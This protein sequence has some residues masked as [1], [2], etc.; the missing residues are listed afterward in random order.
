[1]TAELDLIAAEQRLE[2]QVKNAQEIELEELKLNNEIASLRLKLARL[3]DTKYKIKQETKRAQ[4]ERDSALRKYELEKETVS[5]QKR[6]EERLE[7]ARELLES[8]TWY[9][10]T[11][12]LENHA[13]KW[14]VDGALQLP[15]R[16]LL[17]D[18][19]GLGKTLSSLIWRRVHSIKK[20]LI[21]VRKEVAFDFLKE[22]SIREPNLFVYQ[23]LG[24]D[25]DSRNIAASLLNHQKEFVVITNIESWRKN[26]DKT[27]QDILKIKYDGMI[28]DEA[29]HIKNVTSATAQGFFRLS[30]EIPKVLELTGTPIKNSPL[31]MFSLLH[32]LYPDLFE[33]ESKFKVD[34]C[35]Q[36]D[37]NKWVFTESGLKSLVAK[38]SPFYLARSP[39]D[40]GRLV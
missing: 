37:Q 14:Q 20:L 5:I 40:V 30:K 7:S 34:Y 19:R 8:A 2:L 36:M 12:S 11:Y 18:K 39:E 32:A 17:G 21:C 27:T 33:R 23:L 16:A 26:I 22:L 29:H 10:P 35:K 13:F 6:I 3:K 25:S 4:V 9:D 28:L 1:M 15:E 24:V 31:E 38:I